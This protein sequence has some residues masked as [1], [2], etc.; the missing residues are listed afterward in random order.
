MEAELFREK[1]KRT[2]KDNDL[3]KE[4]DKI[5]VA[6]SGG[7]DS[8]CL[9][10]VLINLKKQMNFDIVV[11]HVNHMIREEADSETEYVKSYCNKNN[12]EIFIKKIDVIKEALKEKIGTEEKGRKIRYEFFDEVLLKTNAN[13]IAIAHNANDNAETVL[14]N[15]I[16]GTGTDGLKGIEYNRDNKI[17]RPILDCN[18]EDIEEYCKIEM[19][20]PKIDKTNKDNTYTRNKI[21]NILIPFIK[22]E[23]NPNI[24]ESLNRLSS[25]SKKETSY[26]NKIIE[27]EYKKIV[28]N[29][30]LSKDMISLYLKKFNDLD[31]VV[32][33]RL[34][35]YTIE[36]L[37]GSTKDIGKIHIDDIIKLCSNNIGNKFLIPNKKIKVLVANKKVHFIN[38]Y[39]L[40]KNT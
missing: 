5:V 12:V 39:E 13:K 15:L 2:I 14:M 4:N 21:R 19:L 30:N 26:W 10:H 40:S 17:I 28:D 33:S 23:F 27:L 31:Y 20:D 38:L 34:I 8:M 7:P 1:V 6:V 37:C 9:L 29:K 18:R 16:R 22:E 32:K 25:L 35:L 36:K 11:A 24:I 3:I